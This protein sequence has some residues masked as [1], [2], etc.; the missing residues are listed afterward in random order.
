MVEEML[1][2]I[3]QD[4]TSKFLIDKININKIKLRKETVYCI[5]IL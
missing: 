1:T 2:N 3:L 4:R 5:S